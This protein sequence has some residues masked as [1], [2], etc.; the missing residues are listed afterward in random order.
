MNL[1]MHLEAVLRMVLEQTNIMYYYKSR[2][3][4]Y[5]IVPLKLKNMWENLEF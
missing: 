2:V 5:I 4:Q 3:L 1:L